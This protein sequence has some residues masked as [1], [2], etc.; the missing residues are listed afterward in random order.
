MSKHMLIVHSRTAPTVEIDAQAGAA[1]IRFKRA[2]VARTLDRS[3]RG[4]ILTVDVD[5]RDEVIG[6]E[7]IG[8]EEI[9]IEKLLAKARVQAPHVPFAR[10]RLRPTAAMP[11]ES[12]A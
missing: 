12:L 10:T 1:Y 2:K 4:L 9:V 6:V 5:A 7:V 11:E 8:C 3:T